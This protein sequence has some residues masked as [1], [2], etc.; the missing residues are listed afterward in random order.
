[1]TDVPVADAEPVAIVRPTVGEEGPLSLRGS[2]CAEAA[3]GELF[4][5]LKI[6]ST[7]KSYW[8]HRA[9][10]DSYAVTGTVPLAEL[11]AGQKAEIRR[12]EVRRRNAPK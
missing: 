7:G 1:M 6:P 12:F 5:L 3:Q 8:L 9:S 10:D 4:P 2:A 11:V